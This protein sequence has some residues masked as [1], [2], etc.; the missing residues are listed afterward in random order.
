MLVGWCYL[1]NGLDA[2]GCSFV[3]HF[4]YVFLKI[5]S[6]G[7]SQYLY[8]KIWFCTDVHNINT[9]RRKS[10]CK[11]LD[12]PF[13]F[14]VRIT[15]TL[16]HL[17]SCGT[18]CLLSRKTI[19]VVGNI[20]QNWVCV[21]GVYVLLVPLLLLYYIG[22]FFLRMRWILDEHFMSN[23]CCNC[24]GS[25]IH[26]Y[27]WLSAL[28]WNFVVKVGVYKLLFIIIIVIKKHKRFCEFLSRFSG[29]FSF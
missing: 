15:Q 16:L 22:N 12:S 3:L 7:V 19:I 29:K 6:I 13:F 24:F 5:I 26:Y 25:N 17:I 8:R 10:G 4:I 18:L 21:W 1:S 2:N 14:V 27:I 20:R 28:V 9:W 23:L 11:P